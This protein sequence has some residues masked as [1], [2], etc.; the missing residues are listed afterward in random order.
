MKFALA[1][2]QA[3]TRAQ[4]AFVPGRA[5]PEPVR[6]L[7]GVPSLS[8]RQVEEWIEIVEGFARRAR[9]LIAANPGQ[10][11]AVMTGILTE[12]IATGVLAEREATLAALRS[13]GR[14]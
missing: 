9:A 13:E 7:L 4:A 6:E 3:Q 14:L 12:A 1:A 2:E 10:V 11:G 5:G 8:E